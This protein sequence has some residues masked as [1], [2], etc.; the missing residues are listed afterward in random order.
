MAVMVRCTFEH[1]VFLRTQRQYKTQVYHAGG[2]TYTV[3]HL[4]MLIFLPPTSSSHIE[5]GYATTAWLTREQRRI[6]I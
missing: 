2:K 1:T 3:S 6:N 4:I 5:G